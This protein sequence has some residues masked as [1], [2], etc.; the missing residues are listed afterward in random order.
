MVLKWL[1][2]VLNLIC[3]DVLFD[4]NIA[5]E[6]NLETGY[7]AD[8]YHFAGNWLVILN[9]HVRHLYPDIKPLNFNCK[10]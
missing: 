2:P 4:I 1:F 6:M 3:K 9:V 5:M 10:Y 7:H 8:W